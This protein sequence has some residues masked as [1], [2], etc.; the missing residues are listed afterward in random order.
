M[1][2]DTVASL[3]HMQQLQRAE[4]TGIKLKVDRK[5]FKQYKKEVFANEFE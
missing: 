5:N 2:Y 3:Q 4:A 1:S